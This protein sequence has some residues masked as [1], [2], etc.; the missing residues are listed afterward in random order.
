MSANRGRAPTLYVQEALEKRQAAADIK[1][2]VPR[3]AE[4][5]L[6]V[7]DVSGRLVRTLV[8]RTMTPGHHSERWDGR[9]QA[10]QSVASGVY[11]ARLRVDQETSI[12]PMALVR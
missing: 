10:G 5:N 3:Q 9:D 7:Y 2:S 12:K 8:S 11:Y 4:V 1:F 6:H